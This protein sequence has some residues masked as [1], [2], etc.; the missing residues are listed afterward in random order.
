MNTISFC[1]LN[2]WGLWGKRLRLV[3]FVLLT[4]WRWNIVFPNLLFYTV[5][6]APVFNP[7]SI[8]FKSRSRRHR[9]VPWATFYSSFRAPQYLQAGSWKRCSWAEKIPITALPGEETVWQQRLFWF[10]SLGQKKEHPFVTYLCQKKRIPA[11]PTVSG[12]LGIVVLCV[13][14]LGTPAEL[15]GRWW[16]RVNSILSR[17]LSIR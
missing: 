13:I 5:V 7:L 4:G 3:I 16:G 10:S 17:Y 14:G 8:P 11:P 15:C 6:P 2:V 12:F 1:L 9:M